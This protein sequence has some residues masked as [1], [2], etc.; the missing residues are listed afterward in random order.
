MNASVDEINLIFARQQAVAP[1]AALTTADQRRAGL[2]RLVTYLQTHLAAAQAALHADMRRAPLDTTAELLLVKNEAD[3]AARRLAGW[4]KP[5]RVRNSLMSRGTMAWLQYEPKG[6][7]LIIAP[8]NAPYACSLVP[9]VGALAAGNCAIVKPSEMAPASAAFLSRM[10]AELFPPEQVAVVEGDAATATA[11][12]N[13]PFN[14]IYFTGNPA[15]GRLVMAAAARHLTPV[16]LELGGK[17]PTIVDDSAEL[18]TAAYKIGWGKC[19]NNGQACV[20]PD[21]VLVQANVAQAFV[22]EVQAAITAMYNADGQGIQVSPAYSRIINARH[23]QR[24]QHLLDDALAKGA[25]LAAGGDGVPDDYY[26]APTLLTNVTHE[27]AIMQEE[28][29]GPILPILTYDTPE[30][31]VALIHRLPKPLALYIYSTH[32]PTINYFLQHTSAGSTVINHNM[33]QAGINPHLP[34]GGVGNSGMG[35]SVGR[36]TFESFSNQRS[37]VRQPTGWRDFS[38]LNLPPYSKTYQRLI[39]FLF[40]AG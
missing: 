29:F 19:A 22:K 15:V 12:L 27:M 31:A 33:I 39:R 18:T 37:V 26:L 36:A 11:L 5:Q 2:E 25:T 9:L 30:Q 38:R 32:Q 4:M 34:F 8:W 20:A 40:G 7:V 13:L 24:L 14:H 23:F 28:V 17:S 1:D 21:Y 6:V 10:L 35:R 16:T 3:F